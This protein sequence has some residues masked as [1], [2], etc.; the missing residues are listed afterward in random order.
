MKALK[1]F[2]IAPLQQL[3]K[4]K[5]PYWSGG[6]VILLIILF[7]AQ[8]KDDFH[9]F[10]SASRDVLAK[11]NIYQIHYN[12]YYHYYYDVLFALLLAPFTYLPLYAVK[13]IW[14]I[15]NV[16]FVYR[17][18]QI[19][20]SWLPMH[21]LHKREKT[22]FSILSFIM[23]SRFLRDNFHLSQVTICMLY[24]TLEG[25]HCISREKKTAG[26]LL[27][28]MGISIKIL[29]IVIIPY[30]LYRNELKAVV[31]TIGFILLCL[32]L[33]ALLI[34]VDYNY[35]LLQERWQLI[36]PTNA[37]HVLDTS[38]R[39]FHSLTTLL[40]TLL[41]EDGGDAHALSLKRNIANISTE[42][43]NIV[44][45]SVRALFM[46]CTLYFLNTKPFQSVTNNLQKLYEISY[47]CLLVPLLFPHQQHYAFFF[48]FPA[49]TYLLFYLV[50]Q[51]VNKKNDLHISHFKTKKTALIASMGIIYIL[52]NSHFILG[53]FNPIYDHYKTLTYGVILL[54]VVLAMCKPNTLLAIN[55][56]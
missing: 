15:L 39:S 28:A 31:Y 53:Q 26:S 11:K 24:L 50:K 56:K 19:L 52:T 42:Q 35:F 1:S 22:L 5:W 34:G 12:D 14:L 51:Y 30:L 16:F 43:L 3:L 25:L 13:V 29:P 7:E 23:I 17:I 49:S 20:T 44:I 2:N 48:I 32:F 8:G 45:N 33:P 40:A 4:P 36:N 18:W 6:F 21:T 41:V 27:L 10:M 47:L 37:T 54:A 9:I 38:E 55:Q 46:L